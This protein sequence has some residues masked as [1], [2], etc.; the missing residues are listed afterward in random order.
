S[1][2]AEPGLVTMQAM[3]A[4]ALF[5]W[6][7]LILIL[8]ALLPARRAVLTAFIVGWLF[9][10][11]SSFKIPGLPDYNKVTATNLGVLMMAMMFDSA[12]MMRFRPRWFDLPALVY[13]VSPFFSSITNNLG[14]YDGLS[15]IAFNLFLWGIPYFIGRVYFNDLT[16]MREL[17]IAVFVGA[18]LY[19]PLCLYEIRMSPQLHKLVYGFLQQTFR[20]SKRW[21]GYRPA[22]FLQHGLAVGMYMCT[23]ALAGWWMWRCGTVKQIKSIPMGLAVVAVLGPALLCKSTG[24]IVLLVAGL[25]VLYVSVKMRMAAPLVCLALF[26]PV[27]I[28]AR[29]FGLWSEQ[30]LTTL[31][32]DLVGNDRA[33]SLAMRLRNEDRLAAKGMERPVFGWGRWGRNQI[34]DTETGKHTVTDGMWVIALGQAGLVGLVSFTLLLLLPVAIFIRGCR[35]RF[36]SQPAIAPAAAMAVLLVIHMIDNLFN[37]LPNPIFMLAAGGLPQV[38]LASAAAYATAK[39]PATRAPTGRLVAQPLMRRV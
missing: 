39:A 25:M 24:A 5:G 20:E 3:A 28:G 12:R 21:G 7:P 31:T 34:I 26:V 23:A 13:C 32:S 36:W 11:M 14:A 1:H 18:M 9:L 37:A 2:A 6:I 8:F 35:P 4:I 10:P 29:T 38:A 19:V 17:A 27:Y 16:G 33:Q 30:Q 22:V 15:A